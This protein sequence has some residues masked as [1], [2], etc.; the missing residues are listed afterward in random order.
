MLE[1]MDPAFGFSTLGL[2]SKLLL[3]D[4][5]MLQVVAKVCRKLPKK[6]KKKVTLKVFTQAQDLLVSFTIT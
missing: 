3:L 2:V 5:W 6:I 4:G 1:E